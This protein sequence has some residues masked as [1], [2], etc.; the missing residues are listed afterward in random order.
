MN[1]NSKFISK[2]SKFKKNN[3][4]Q[5]LKKG[6]RETNKIIKIEYSNNINDNENTKKNVKIRN[7][8]VDLVRIIAMIGIIYNHLIYQDAAK[9]KYSKFQ[10]LKLLF[11]FLFWHNNGY[12]LISGVIGYKTNKY[13]NLLYF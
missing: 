6:K 7:P 10:H 2:R 8:G 3:K 13:S 9:T 5:K 4:I 12:A 1:E 11:V